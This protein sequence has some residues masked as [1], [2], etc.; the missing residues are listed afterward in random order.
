MIK[1]FS[2][3]DDYIEFSTNMSISENEMFCLNF[4]PSA[5]F[6]KDQIQIFFQKR[7]PLISPAVATEKLWKY[8]KKVMR[9]LQNNQVKIG[10]ENN[11]L[12]N[13]CNN[14]TIHDA[15]PGFEIGY[16]ARVF[17]L[18]KMLQASR[19]IF[20]VR[21]PLPFTFR[22]HSPDEVLI[23]V[24]DNKH[25]QKIQGIWLKD[26]KAFEDFRCEFDRLE[27]CAITKNNEENFKKEIQSAINSLKNG[28]NYHWQLV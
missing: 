28:E 21:D 24:K 4:I 5:F 19:N 9:C 2:T 10:I 12:I 20:L 14:G 6:P 15:T 27:N 8:G 3:N 1:V 22:L 26:K 17:A 7:E 16:S 18:E 23:D 11:S 13:M 25:D